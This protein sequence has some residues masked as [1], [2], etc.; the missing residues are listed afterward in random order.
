MVIFRFRRVDVNNLRKRSVCA[1]QS[2]CSGCDN[3]QFPRLGDSFTMYLRKTLLMVLISSILWLVAIT[4]MLAFMYETYVPK[5]LFS[6]WIRMI[7]QFC[8]YAVLRTSSMPHPI[9]LLFCCL[10]NPRGFRLRNPHLTHVLVC[11]LFPTSQSTVTSLEVWNTSESHGTIVGSRCACSVQKVFVVLVFAQHN[12]NDAIH[13]MLPGQPVQ[14]WC[15]P[16]RSWPVS[17]MDCYYLVALVFC[18]CELWKRSSCIW[19]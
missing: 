14:A 17:E 5:T 10:T 9:V 4:W 3:Q 7:L 11:H 16:A 15:L 2:L 18:N 13:F 19:L 1:V 6:W 8:V 12:A